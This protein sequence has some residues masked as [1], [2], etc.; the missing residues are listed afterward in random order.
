VALSDN[1]DLPRPF[2]PYTLLRRLAVGGMAEVYV[3]KARGIG[4]FEKLVAIKVIHPRYSE[5]DHFVTML[6]DEAKLSVLLTHVNIAQTFDLGCNEETYYIVMELVEGADAYKL[7]KR[8]AERP[9]KIP[10]DI[11][12][13]V[14]AEMCQGLDYAH[15]K[16]DVTGASLRIVHR[17]ISPQN[18]LISFAGEVKI[19]DFGI[20]K[21][22]LRSGNTEVG[23]IK[24]KYYYMSPE[25]A[26]AD[27]VDARS[28][29]FSTGIVLHELL[30]GKMVYEED[31]LPN[32]LARVRK[33]EIPPPSRLRPE[34]PPEL[35][36][37]VMKALAK[38]PEERYAT[39]H[40]FGQALTQFLYGYLP[41]FTPARLAGMMYQLFPSEIEA[42]SG[43]VQLPSGQQVLSSIHTEDA[44]EDTATGPVGPMRAEEFRLDPKKSVIFDLGDDFGEEETSNQLPR[45]LAARR[46]AARAPESEWD[47]PTTGARP[48]AKVPP[49]PE[50][51]ATED[52]D[53]WEDATIVDDSE[54]LMARMRGLLER[55]VAERNKQGPPPSGD[56]TLPFDRAE[57]PP[58]IRAKAAAAMAPR[59]GTP[60][61][62]PPRP[63]RPRASGPPRASAPPPPAPRALAAA[64][65]PAS[66]PAAEPWTMEAPTEE[67]AP[68]PGEALPDLSGWMDSSSEVRP[69]V[70][71][72]PAAATG[73]E[74]FDTHQLAAMTAAAKSRARRRFLLGLGAVLLAVAVF[75][76]IRLTRSAPVDPPRLEVL[77]VPAGAR[78]FFDGE[79]LEGT[80]PLEVSEGIEVGQSYPVQVQLDG[81][82]AWS[83]TYEAQVGPMQ[84][85]AV[86][87]PIRVDVTLRTDPPG[88]RV[89]V[90]GVDHGRA[91]V[92]LGRRAVGEELRLRARV[93]GREVRETRAIAADARDIVL[94]P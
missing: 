91:P 36:E 20:A 80:T 43:G 39:A 57:L 6:V 25:Q 23:V 90:D 34:V 49:P 93:D 28:D 82:E 72:R 26:W 73:G 40:D 15:R 69:A 89:W 35:D 67:S 54:N 14:G 47:E 63:G 66:A 31:N 48:A 45:G 18:V 62:P 81:Y 64:G 68:D 58:A 41:S 94:S 88:G 17:D 7:L 44:A 16:R 37:I 87:V 53:T 24:G 10:I 22:A 70:G 1:M 9:A 50:T 78:V 85:I 32:L 71:Q 3:A 2:G 52:E 19:V 13:Y 21:A 59:R 83:S 11:A 33:A 46:Q 30:T 61:P 27:P 42:S 60:P 51:D 8:A 12:A 86:L 92:E 29:I 56:P 75:L 79:E 65:G 84:Q 76:L 4:G 38:Y 55:Q 74:T 5:D 77:S